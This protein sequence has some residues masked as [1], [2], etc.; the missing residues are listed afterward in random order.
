MR[1]KQ[2]EEIQNLKMRLQMGRTEDGV[3]MAILN[4]VRR[5]TKKHSQKCTFLQ[6]VPMG[7]YNIK[8]QA[9]MK[10]QELLGWDAFLQGLISTKWA[11]AQ[12]QEQH[13][14]APFDEVE[15]N[16]G[17]IRGLLDF[18]TAMWKERNV[19]LH[20][21]TIKESRT[22]QLEKIRE[23]IDELYAHPYRKRLLPEDDRF[24][25]DITAEKRK[26]YGIQAATTWVSVVES[27][28]K[29]HREEAA[30]MTI[31]KYV[32]EKKRK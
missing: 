32:V 2:E 19:T 21:D 29:M 20:G 24:L 10:E 7:D 8:L 13:L 14:G 22:K 30:K 17:V 26:K 4:M 1:D 16:R 27:R 31:H 15:W 9:A 5:Y 18:S 12:K 11:E 23:K 28:I 3:K 25:F 6:E